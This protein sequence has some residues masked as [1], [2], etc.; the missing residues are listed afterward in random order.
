MLVTTGLTVLGTL[1]L[2]VTSYS[3]TT[4]QHPFAG[5][6]TESKGSLVLIRLFPSAVSI[7]LL[8]ERREL[9]TA[10]VSADPLDGFGR[11]QL[12]LRFE[13]GAFA[14]DTVGLDAVQ[15]RTLG[16]QGT[17]QDAHPALASDPPVVGA[18]PG[19][20]ALT[21]MPSRVVPH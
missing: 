17:N 13:D 2:L 6:I 18:N 3:T 14:V 7:E 9:F 19:A 20:H 12:A 5:C 1:A 21:I 10:E 11:R 15:P 4:N 8:G 16:R